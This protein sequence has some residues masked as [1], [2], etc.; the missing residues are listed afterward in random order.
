MD[1]QI[2]I[3]CKNNKGYTPIGVR[4]LIA[5][6]E[7]ENPKGIEDFLNNKHKY[8]E[9]QEMYHGIFLA[10][11][12]YKKFGDK[13]KFNICTAVSDPPDL[14]F[15]ENNGDGA[16]AVEVMEIYKHKSDFTDYEELVKHIWE[17]KGQKYDEQYYLLLVS[18]LNRDFNV[19]KFVEELKKLEWNFHRIFISLYTASK[20]Q[21]TFFEVFPPAQYNDSNYMSFN[22]QEDK[23]LWY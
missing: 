4:N 6:V 2:N 11:A 7:K 21:W 9:L 13:Y 17:K 10:L 12:L 16:F 8:K 14:Y 3:Q 22:L 19:T 15:L 23:D 20:G 1:D 5:Q 18:R